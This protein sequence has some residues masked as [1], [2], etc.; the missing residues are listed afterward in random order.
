[1]LGQ[2]SQTMKM[3]KMQAVGICGSGIIEAIVALAEA[4]IIDQSGLFVES[5][6]PELFSK[7]GNTSRFLL[8]EQGDKSI[9]VEQVDIRSIQLAKAALSAGV[10]ILMDYLECTGV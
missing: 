9:Y 1:M 7:K 2:M 3:L 10:S 4:G 5:I 8:V 6:A